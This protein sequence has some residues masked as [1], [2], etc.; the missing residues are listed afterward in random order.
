MYNLPNGLDYKVGLKGSK[1]SGG[2]KQ[3]IAIARALVIKPKILIL[4]EATSALDNKSE[5]IIQKALDNITK[6][7]I[8]TIIIA[9]RLSTI[10]NS[11][12]IYVIKDG[13]VLEKG[14]HEE[15]LNKG[16]YYTDIIKSQLIKEEL[17]NHNKEEEYVRKGGYIKRV[18]TKE[19][20]HFERRDN[21]ISKSPDDIPFSLC[22]FIK[23]LWNFKF[24]FILGLISLIIYGI[25]PPVSGLYL[26][27]VINS[28]NS[29]YQTIRYDI[30]N[31]KSF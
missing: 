23:D 9:H 2:Q 1:L 18:N 13:K 12:I 11:D 21:E 31:N 16:G 27:N 8:T 22:K 14:N 5:K 3:R 30:F 4:D 6:M 24:Y 25:L 10:K 15:L 7:N 20:V 28:L 17:E 26:G 19:E 29:R